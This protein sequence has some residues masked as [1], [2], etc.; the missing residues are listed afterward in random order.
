MAL[1]NERC[2]LKPSSPQN[3]KYVAR[4]HKGRGDLARAER[5]QARAV[6]LRAA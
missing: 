2:A 5:A 3:W 1:A 6:S 4:A